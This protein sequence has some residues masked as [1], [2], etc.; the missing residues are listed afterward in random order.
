MSDTPFELYLVPVDPEPQS[1]Y[2][3]E[4]FTP[5]TQYRLALESIFRWTLRR[6]ELTDAEIVRAIKKVSIVALEDV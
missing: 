6:D 2:E 1:P 3:F 5:E 4:A